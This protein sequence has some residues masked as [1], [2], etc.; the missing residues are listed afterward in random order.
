MKKD[1]VR[2][3][4][5]KVV[6]ERDSLDSSSVAAM[7]KDT[8]GTRVDYALDNGR[9]VSVAFVDIPF[10]GVLANRIMNR[11]TF[12]RVK[13]T[14]PFRS[15]EYGSNAF[16]Y[17]YIGP[18]ILEAY[19]H[20]LILSPNPILDRRHQLGEKLGE[21]S[22]EGNKVELQYFSVGKTFVRGVYDFFNT[23]VRDNNVRPLAIYDQR[24]L[25]SL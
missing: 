15:G 19:Q 24:G 20:G 7:L 18:R 25:L 9:L 22:P 21:K 23:C 16:F 3:R 4:I 10:E 11:H 13:Q 5:P 17:V 14:R 12:S 2:Q 6:L 1:A 8:P